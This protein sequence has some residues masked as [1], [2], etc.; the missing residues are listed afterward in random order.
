MHSKRAVTLI[1]VMVGIVITTIIGGM[2][3]AF[4]SSARH[5]AAIATAKARAKQDAQIIIRHL[6]KDI[7]NSRAKI[8]MKNG[9]PVVDPDDSNKFL[10]ENT[11]EISANKIVAYIPRKN[12]GTDKTYFDSNTDSENSDYK[13]VEYDISGKNLTRTEDS[14]T[15][16]LSDGV[17]EL[18]AEEDYAGK[19]NI[20]L[21]VEKRIP[22][23]NDFVQHVERTAITIRQQ[24]AA[25]VDKR[26]K[27]RIK[28]GDY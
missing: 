9:K 28:A 12:T 6:D 5:S 7:S 26:W 3:F 23:S 2:V 10:V 27:K 13:K 25:S 24:E 1:E 14:K 21:T 17:K 22:G 11:L 8:K 15:V 19:I 16:K 18:K 20:T 4:I